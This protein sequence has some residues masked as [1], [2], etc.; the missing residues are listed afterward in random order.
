MKKFFPLFEKKKLTVHTQEKIFGVLDIGSESVKFLVARKENKR[1]AILGK[2]L[3]GYKRFS[4]F[5]GREFELDVMKRAIEVATAKAQEEASVRIGSLIVG[6]PPHIFKARICHQGYERVHPKKLIE[7][8]EKEK[9]LKIISEKAK[10]KVAEDFAAQ[11]GILPEELHFLS[12]RILQMKIDGY[13]VPEISGFSGKKLEFTVLTTFLPKYY[14]DRAKKLVEVAG[15]F[16]ISKIL[17]ES[18]G[19]TYFLSKEQ[20]VLFLDIGADFT[21]IFEVKKGILE[22]VSEFR[23]GGKNFSQAICQ[24]LGILPIR[25]KALSER[26]QKALLGEKMRSRLKEMFLEEAQ[27]WFLNLKERVKER[28]FFEDIFCFG[29]GANFVE[30]REILEKNWGTSAKILELKDLPGVEDRTKRKNNLQFLPAIFLV[31]AA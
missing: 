26:Y 19:L 29:G 25:A 15:P 16:K 3:Q 13:E 17:H 2:A 23:L 10:I 5:D 12:R 21:Q 31:R 9:I 11:T 8:E 7:K 6:F 30:I 27:N 1:I 4:V 24:N 20:N 28:F 14:E 22:T 18:E